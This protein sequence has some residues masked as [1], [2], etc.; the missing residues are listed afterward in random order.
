[1]ACIYSSLMLMPVDDAITIFFTVPMFTMMFSLVFLRTP[2]KLWKMSAAL[3]L[4]VGAILV[5]KP[6]LFFPPI[7]LVRNA[8]GVDDNYL[9]CFGILM[10]L[11]VALFGGLSNVSVAICGQ[12]GTSMIVFYSGLIWMPVGIVA[13]S[14]DPSQRFISHQLSDITSSEW[15]EL[16]LQSNIQA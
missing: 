12:I 6:P 3:L 14:F 7:N 11:G 2:V 16:M 1:M 13:S 5:V 15:A 8:E 10:A 9:Y 4:L